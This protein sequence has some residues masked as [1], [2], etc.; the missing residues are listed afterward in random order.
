MMSAN[1]IIAAN[2][3]SAGAHGGRGQVRKYTG[4]PYVTHPQEVARLVQ[5]V[6]SDEEIVAAALLHDVVEDTDVD[7]QTIRAF[8]GERVASLVGGLTDVSKLGEGNRASRKAIDRAHTAA[9]HP[10]VMT[11]KL[12]DLIDN[13]KSIV[14]YDPK[15]AKTY[16]EE[17]RLLLE[18]LGRGDPILFRM[19]AKLLDDSLEKLKLTEETSW[20]KK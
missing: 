15:F 18:V 10:D 11:I 4:E 13:T 3:F 2:C 14:K 20:L 12:A 9:Q 6:T 1:F 19:A 17:K 16:L 8:F 5:T 7:L